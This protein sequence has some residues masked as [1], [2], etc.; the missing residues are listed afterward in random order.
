MPVGL[1]VSP[2]EEGLEPWEI[3][4][5]GLHRMGRSDLI[6]N[7]PQHLVPRGAPTPGLQAI[8]R[9]RETPGPDKLARKFGQNKPRPGA[10][11]QRQPARN[12]AGKSKRAV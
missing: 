8:E 1:V 10:A 11:V 3:L 5:E 4:R 9:K 2:E 6:G 7:G 12:A